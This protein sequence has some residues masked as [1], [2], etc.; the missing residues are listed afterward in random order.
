MEVAEKHLPPGNFVRAS[1]TPLFGWHGWQELEVPAS[2][3]LRSSRDRRRALAFVP[4][5]HLV[6][7]EMFG[8][9]PPSP[10]Q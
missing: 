10:I 1:L 4:G 2:A 8:P 7:H 9:P 5:K 3:E 6:N